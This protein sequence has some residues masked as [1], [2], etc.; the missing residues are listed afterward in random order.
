MGHGI[1]HYY[2]DVGQNFQSKNKA[3]IGNI[4]LC[5]FAPSLSTFEWM[6]VQSVE[7]KEQSKLVVVGNSLLYLLE[8]SDQMR[9]IQNPG[10]VEKKRKN[11]RATV[12]LLSSALD[13]TRRTPEGSHLVG[14]ASI[15]PTRSFI[16]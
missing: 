3:T 7:I 15:G 11:W 1:Y 6:L 9:I 12:I 16:H 10:C 8:K 5:I 14:R 4:A 2:F 13:V